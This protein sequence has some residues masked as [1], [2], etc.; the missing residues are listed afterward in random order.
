VAPLNGLARAA[1]A[2]AALTAVGCA[3]DLEPERLD[4]LDVVGRV[5]DAGT[6]VG[7]PGV[8]VAVHA[9]AGPMGTAG[10]ASSETDSDGGY[11]LSVTFDGEGILCEPGWLDLGVSLP[12]GYAM[13]EEP[14]APLLCSP[15]RQHRDL[16]LVRV[17]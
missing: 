3:T 4:G 12:D 15:Q 14:F 8:S 11:H 7:L 1:V 10:L 13:N 6:G 17:D 16:A 5:Y 2:I 9:P